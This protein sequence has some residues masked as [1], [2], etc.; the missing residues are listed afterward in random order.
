MF[1]MQPVSNESFAG[2]TFA[3][4]DLVLMM[5]KNQIDSAGVK[6]KGLAQIFH[7][8]R[9]AF[10]MPSGPAAANLCVPGRLVRV[11]RRLPQGKVARGS[12]LIFIR[13]GALASARSVG[14]AVNLRRFSVFG[15]GFDSII[16]RLV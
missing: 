3:L 11:A 8:H 6:V 14:R 4:G 7:G 13:V 10:D 16:N 12:L 9:G 2:R 15:T 1:V 5:R